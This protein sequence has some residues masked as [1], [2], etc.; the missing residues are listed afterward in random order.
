MD[1]E[2]PLSYSAIGGVELVEDTAVSIARHYLNTIRGER[3][4]V[5]EFGIDLQILFDVNFQFVAAEQVRLKLDDLTG[6]RTN[7]TFLQEPR[8]LNI[9]VQVLDK[10]IVVE[11]NS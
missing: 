7:V 8:K 5:E 11:L 3:Q 6:G 9:I 2:F 4:L 1:V 10:E